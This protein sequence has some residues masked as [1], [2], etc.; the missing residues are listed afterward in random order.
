MRREAFHLRAAW[1]AALLI[2]LI[3][4]SA[5]AQYQTGSLYGKAMAKDGS[6]LPGV[7]R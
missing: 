2:A 5:S 1:V 3:A 7:T 4:V 6:L